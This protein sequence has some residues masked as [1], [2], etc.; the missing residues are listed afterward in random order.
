MNKFT[1]L[2]LALAAIPLASNAGIDEGI[3]AFQGRKYGPAWAEFEPLATQGTAE[4][5]YY[6]GE[7]YWHGLGID[8]DRQL[9]I[10]WY[11][12][13]ADQGHAGAQYWLGYIYA[14][15]KQDA[16]NSSRAIAWFEKAAT[17][18]HKQ[19][20]AELEAAVARGDSDAMASLVRLES[21]RQKLSKADDEDNAKKAEAA[22][23][24]GSIPSIFRRVLTN[25]AYAYLQAS[26][27][28]SSL[29]PKAS[30]AWPAVGHE[31]IPIV[32]DP[33]LQ[34]QLEWEAL[35]NEILQ[36]RFAGQYDRA[37]ATAERALAFAVRL[38]G[39]DDPN[40]AKS[41]TQLAISSQ[42]V[43]RYDQAEQLYKRALAITEKSLGFEHF[44]TATILSD[45]ALLYKTQNRASLA[46]P[47]LRRA[48]AIIEKARGPNHLDMAKILI[49][50]GGALSAQ[51]Q[52][53]NA[54]EI[55]TRALAIAEE[56]SGL[57]NSVVA[58]GLGN[59]ATLDLYKG[60]YTEAEQRLKRSLLI[61]DKQSPNHPTTAR[62]KV[63]LAHL[64]LVQGRYELAEGIYLHALK[65]AKDTFGPEH[66]NVSATLGY[67]ARLYA[68]QG[69]HAKALVSARGASAIMRKRLIISADNSDTSQE[70]KGSI[71]A[72]FQHLSLL[73]RNPLGDPAEAV[74]DEAFQLIQLAQPTTTGAAV[75]RM[76][77]RFSQG[78]SSLA[79]LVKR[80][81]DAM[82]KRSRE[83]ARLIEEASKVPGKR[84]AATENSLRAVV[85]SLLE[86]IEAIDLELTQ[87]FPDYQELNRVEPVS[88]RSVQSLLQPGEAMIVYGAM[89]ARR[90]HYLYLDEEARRRLYLWV[91]RSDDVQFLPLDVALNPLEMDLRTS[92]NTI[93]Y[94]SSGTPSDVDVANLHSIYRRILS[95]AE[96]YLKGVR[97]IIVVPTAAL[98]GMPFSVLVAKP[99]KPNSDSSVDYRRVDWF[100]Q[101]YSL[102]YL[103]SVSSIRALRE[104]QRGGEAREP[105]V[106]FGDPLLEGGTQ[107]KSRNT[108]SLRVADFSL[109]SDSGADV[110]Q[111]GVADVRLIRQQIRLRETETEIRAMAKILNSG[112]DSI[113][114]QERA[115]EK[116]VKTMDL[117]RY[118]TIVFATHG[119]M[120]GEI[121]VDMEPGLLLTPPGSGTPE[122][123]GYLSAGEIAELKVNAELVI[124]SACNTAATDGTPD[125]EGLSG[126]AKAF[127]Y[128]GARSLLV[129]H[130]P[131]AS[132][133]TVP[134]TTGMLMEY[135]ANPGAGKA[136]AHRKALMALM[137]T[138]DHP[139]YAHPFFWAPF[140]V[141]GEGGVG[142][143][144]FGSL[145]K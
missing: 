75:I 117:A 46:E 143:S 32:L 89:P 59:L 140:V 19:A 57:E 135:E 144:K 49:N 10:E 129:S 94:S 47:L 35:N 54:E 112:Q 100:G 58:T 76:A 136:E 4:A 74:A 128:S 66:I 123:D 24:S 25:E 30:P 16:M 80:K 60:R 3:K 110:R 82:G 44:N 125:A 1:V 133:A 20:L 14:S 68:K 8:K 26:T 97:H 124:L 91:I 51:G 134:L 118:R 85:A 86:Q 36:L 64:Y 62:L 61:F 13:A 2:L 90:R 73:E 29:E 130:W 55:F 122:D 70:S 115:T 52:Y 120:A 83:E 18:G 31:K 50:L 131:V 15:D 22:K 105:F 102:S 79:A 71:N 48:A 98:F 69:A 104:F 145:T 78:D 43:G 72:L 53:D 96:A 116:N 23:Q 77:S 33:T 141:V 107:G 114:L 9:A 139:E 67:L 95:P 111:V 119:V 11:R 38:F 63:I 45:L 108:A 7:L 87:R 81:Q 56:A 6:L 40:V 84:N 27:A 113:W 65:L 93:T 101:K 109:G 28:R 138:P 17:A 5:Q 37:L 132:E 127:F 42:V 39:E 126:L 121:G 137:A 88:L 92:R 12:K 142:T 41:M 21:V 106:G 34:G 103:P 99:P